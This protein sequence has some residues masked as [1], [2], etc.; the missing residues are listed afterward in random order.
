[1]LSEVGPVQGRSWAVRVCAELW[2]KLK[3]ELEKMKNCDW[4]SR[5]R[6]RLPQRTVLR[7]KGM[8]PLLGHS[9]S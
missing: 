3:P 9:P 8:P 2:W 1:M 7:R 4:D 6:D 5:G